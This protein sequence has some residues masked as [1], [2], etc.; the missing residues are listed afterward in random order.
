VAV[1]PL[2]AIDF[3]RESMGESHVSWLWTVAL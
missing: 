3:S 1:Y 2:K